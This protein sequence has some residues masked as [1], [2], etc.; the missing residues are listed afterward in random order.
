MRAIKLSA[1]QLRPQVIDIEYSKDT[2]LKTM[3]DACQTTCISIFT[4]ARLIKETG[5][6]YFL[7]CD[8]NA[9]LMERPKENLLASACSGRREALFG[10]VLI[11]K[12]GITDGEPDL[13]PVPEEEI[14]ELLWL[15]HGYADSLM[16]AL[17]GIENDQ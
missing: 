12:D 13:V 17:K 14:D 3:Q 2:W 16:L 10:D 1:G 5:Q 8:E 9:L 15:L 11:V 4:P 6:M 7:C